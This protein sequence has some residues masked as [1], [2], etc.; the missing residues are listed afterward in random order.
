MAAAAPAYV[1]LA[2]FQRVH[3]PVKAPVLRRAVKRALIKQ[4]RDIDQSRA[5]M[6]RVREFAI[7]GSLLRVIAPVA[8]AREIMRRPRQRPHLT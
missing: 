8:T 2:A 3:M 6:L 4:G 5:S 1:K 7:F